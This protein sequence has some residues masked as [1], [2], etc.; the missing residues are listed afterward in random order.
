MNYFVNFEFRK[1]CDVDFKDYRYS[2]YMYTRQYVRVVLCERSTTVLVVVVLGVCFSSYYCTISYALLEK[3]ESFDLA[4]L[5]L[6]FLVNGGKT[7]PVAMNAK[8]YK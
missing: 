4:A 2:S 1:Q 6:L 7:A 8:L 5:G 3:R